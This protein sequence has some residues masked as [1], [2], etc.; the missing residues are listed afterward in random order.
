MSKKY[1]NSP[2]IEAVCTF[3]FM[4]DNEW[5][6]TYPGQIYDCVSSDFPKKKQVNTIDMAVSSKEGSIRQN[7]QTGARIQFLNN[8]ENRLYQVGTN[9]L[10]INY[11]KPYDSWTNYLPMIKN[12]LESYLNIVNPKAIKLASLRYINHIKFEGSNIK[13]EDYFNFYPSTKSEK[14]KNFNSFI[15]GI[16]IFYDD[17]KDILKVMLLSAE[18]T[19]D[20]TNTAI[21]D[22]E[23]FSTQEIDIEQL[24]IIEWVKSAHDRVEEVFESCIKDNLRDIFGIIE[25][26]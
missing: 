25:N 17:S 10:S 7:L 26:E 22:L 9:L 15:T 3:H 8:H 11:L 24:K 14:I 20:I 6:L 21:L 1:K 13:L 23:Y 2:I 18:P 5:D 4:S 16:Q 19:E 12:G